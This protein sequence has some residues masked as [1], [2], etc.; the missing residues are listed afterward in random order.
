MQDGRPPLKI[1]HIR[2]VE[3][4]GERKKCAKFGFFRRQV[5]VRPVPAGPGCAILSRMSGLQIHVLGGFELRVEDGGLLV[6]PTRKARTLLAILAMTPGMKQ[7]RHGLAAMLWERSAE[8]QARATLRQTLSSIRKVLN[9]EAMDGVLYTDSDEVGL[10]TER[11]AVDAVMFERFAEQHS[12]EALEQAFHLYKGD[13]L[14]G[15]SLREAAFEDWL[16]A[17]R[18]RLQETARRALTELL[19]HL[20]DR[21]DRSQAAEVASR[22]LAIDPLQEPVHRAL[23]KIH[24]MEGRRTSA[25]RQFETCKELLDRELQIEPEEATRVMAQEI[26]DGASV[27]SGAPRQAADPTGARSAGAVSGQRESAR[28]SAVRSMFP[29]E[30]RPVTVLFAGM[31]TDDHNDSFD[32]EAHH[33]FATAFID[34]VAG[35]ASRYGGRVEKQLGD[36]TV[37]TFGVPTASG[38]DPERALRAALDICSLPSH[39]GEGPAARVGVAAGQVVVSDG[40]AG[41]T[42]TG[43]TINLAHRLETMAPNGSALATEPVCRA[44]ERFVEHAALTGA[45]ISSRGRELPVHRVTSIR[46]RPTWVR[47]TRFIG[48]T[49]ELRQAESMLAT[50]VESGYGQVILLRGEPGIGKT[51]LAEEVEGRART[52]GYRC[53]KVLVFDFGSGRGEDVPRALT[54]SLLGV[55]TDEDEP[56][57]TRQAQAAIDEGRTSA[58]RRVFLNDLL[59]LP[60]PTE[61]RSLYDAMDDGVRNQGKQALMVDLIHNASTRTPVLVTVEDVHWTDPVVLDY[62]AAVALSVRNCRAVLMLTSRVE[63][64]PIDR[65]WR[66]TVRE[67]PLFT[68]D[69]GPLREAE[70]A[71]LA[72][73]FGAGDEDVVDRCLERADGNPLFLEQLLRMSGEQAAADAVP[74]TVQELALARS[75]RLP[76]ADKAALQAASVIGQRFSIAA[77]RHLLGD[78]R[79]ECRE[80]VDKD[81]I[82]PDQNDF[83]FAHALIRD[84]IYTSL[85]TSTRRT[86]HRA[87]A[88]WFE[89]R[90]PILVA[91]HLDAAEDERAA[92]AYLD[93]ASSE[94]DAYR[95]TSALD[96]IERAL[97]VASDQTDRFELL[98]LKG[99]IRQ[100]IGPLSECIN[101]LRQA[102][103]GAPDETCRCRALTSLAVGLRQHSD[104]QQAASMLDE[105]EPIAERNNLLAELSRIHITRANLAFRLG[106]IDECLPHHQR[107]LKYARRAG[108][109][110]F[111]THSLGGLGDA[112]YAMG[113]MR[114]AAKY[115]NECTHAAREHGLGRIESAHLV[116]G[117][118]YWLLELERNENESLEV[119]EMAIRI[120]TSLSEMHCY[121]NV[122]QTA[123]ARSELPRAQEYAER[124]IAVAERVGT[125]RFKARGLHFLGQ[126]LMAMGQHRRGR[127]SLDQALALSKATGLGYC[128]PGIIGAIV[129]AENNPRKRQPLIEEGRALLGKGAVAHNFMEFYRDVIEA[130]LRAQ[131]CDGAEHNA[132]MLEKFFAPEPLPLTD[133]LVARGRALSAHRRG[134]RDDGLKVELERLRD[135]ALDTDFR[136]SLPAIDD[137]LENW[138]Q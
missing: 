40:E 75:D 19:E 63:G 4:A 62:L 47:S 130:C 100:V 20:M 119:A 120:G 94:A 93:A 131:D 32:I 36:S 38:N 39:G 7:T 54:C 43:D 99:E 21:D 125:E 10:D 123:Y 3:G 84:G 9:D 46:D 111:E 61:L 51:R 85:L 48:R 134:R 12:S 33:R 5:G 13:F 30:I 2:P 137:C 78:S 11:C 122:S 26:R 73:E 92:R 102:I 23:M 67:T 16:A 77:L 114:T 132:A 88:D 116:M 95:S 129:L 113:R 24:L 118:A 18:H 72:R 101:T 50:C 57:R 53:Y 55:G 82:R 138:T 126:A 42:L 28:E 71:T 52:L 29:G 6:L 49:G 74:E 108:S 79:Y 104:F 90:D 91:R 106:R 58:D 8:E 69:I 35:I 83:L 70:A 41:Y 45:T 37:V 15:L 27:V 44:A 68:L 60:Q 136:H 81:L 133:H 117:T 56:G 25:L 65:V 66:T 17:E 76:P 121:L 89:D 14:A 97:E 34:S 110:E 103:D 1:R 86:L 109:K 31:A 112:Y 107:A 22:L 124:A 80:L 59:D 115:L 96:L 105:A 64:D 135:E 128:G 98:H 127:E 87:A